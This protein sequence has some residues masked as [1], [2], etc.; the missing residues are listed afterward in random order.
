MN[1]YL[2]DKTNP[3]RDSAME[4]DISIHEY[5]HGISNRLTGGASNAEC[6]EDDISSGLDEGWSDAMAIFISRNTSHTR[7]DDV[8]IGD[9]VCNGA[10]LRTLP[11]STNL[12]RNNLKCKIFSFSFIRFFTE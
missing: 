1:L 2:F 5:Q 7:N 8:I 12:E 9:Y 11:Y 6:L 3:P 10:N 4:N